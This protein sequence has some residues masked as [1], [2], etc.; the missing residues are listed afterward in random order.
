[1]TTRQGAGRLPEPA[2][3]QPVSVVRHRLQRYGAGRAMD[4]ALDGPEQIAQTIVEEL[5]RP[6]ACR[7]VDGGGAARAAALIAELS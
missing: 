4:F 7:P 5:G 6:T 3:S 1:M 2:L